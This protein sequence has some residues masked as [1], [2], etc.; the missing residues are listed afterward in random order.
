MQI[1]SGRVGRTHQHARSQRHPD[2]R[3]SP[4]PPGAWFDPFGHKSAA[5]LDADNERRTPVRLAHSNGSRHTVHARTA[6]G[7]VLREDLVVH[8]NRSGAE[9]G[10]LRKRGLGE[11]EAVTVY[12]WDPG[13]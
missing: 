4:C 7:R 3:E 8:V 9:A 5:T 10:D 2:R 6:S 12:V 13:R 1:F 11:V